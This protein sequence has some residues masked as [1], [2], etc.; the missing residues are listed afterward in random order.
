MPI[1]IKDKQQPVTRELDHPPK[2]FQIHT[3]NVPKDGKQS[4]SPTGTGNQ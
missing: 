3:Q 1:T 2:S 4:D